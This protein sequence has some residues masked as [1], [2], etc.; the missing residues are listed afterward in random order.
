MN[1]HK[2]YAFYLKDLTYDIKLNFFI[3]SYAVQGKKCDF[4][5]SA[6]MKRRG[7][8]NKPSLMVII[9]LV[10]VDLLFFGEG[11]LL[12]L[13]SSSNSTLDL[14]VEVIGASLYSLLLVLPS[15]SGLIGS[16]TDVFFRI[17]CL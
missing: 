4:T 14:V 8:F 3:T 10:T 2:F 5:K 6:H 9:G 17:P 13:T 11:V 15:I 12:L 7:G 16:E 1:L